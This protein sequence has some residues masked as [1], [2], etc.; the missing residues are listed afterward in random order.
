[1]A[2]APLPILAPRPER[3]VS[4]VVT[5]EGRCTPADVLANRLDAWH[6]T[7]LHNYSFARLRV[8]SDD[9]D[10]LRVRV[11]VR[12]AGPLCVETDCTFH[13]PEPRT[14]V[15]TIVDGEGQGTVVETHATP[16]TRE[17]TRLVE[18]TLAASPR[19]G[20][21]VAFALRP[22]VARL[23]ELAAARLWRD[24]LAYAERMF[25]LRQRRQERDDDAARLEVVGSRGTP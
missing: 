25:T 5:M 15:M 17:R 6:G 11:A 16:I 20:F 19:P 24:D 3:F 12:L 10:V 8:L 18:A 2:A 13:S 22:V 9:D 7:H 21:R 14:I 1:V 23:I 4:G